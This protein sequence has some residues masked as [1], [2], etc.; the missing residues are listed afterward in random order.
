[1][2]DKSYYILSS[3]LFYF[4]HQQKMS[5][6]LIIC[7]LLMKTLRLRKERPHSKHPVE[8]S[9]RQ[10]LHRGLEGSRIPWYCFFFTLA[11]CPHSQYCDPTVHLI[12]SPA[13]LAFSPVT[14]KNKSLRM[15]TEVDRIVRWPLMIYT[16]DASSP[17]EVGSMNMVEYPSTDYSIIKT[18][19][20]V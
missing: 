12:P 5:G 6:R 7:S 13:L 15:E 4:I 14:L 16:I 1:M 11:F 18:D 19:L 8:K 20:E 3:T 9:Q 17:W 2:S 10:I